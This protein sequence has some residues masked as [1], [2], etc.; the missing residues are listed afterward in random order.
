[1]ATRE[2][3]EKEAR[4]V[5][6]QF[7]TNGDGTISM[8]ELKKGLEM[9]IGQKIPDAAMSVIFQDVDRD[10]DGRV[11]FAEFNRYMYRAIELGDV[12]ERHL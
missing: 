10:G 2:D 9:A 1:M 3:L 12:D 5:F 7:D 4:D 11:S 8:K 6:K